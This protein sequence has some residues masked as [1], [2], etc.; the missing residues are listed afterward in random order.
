MKVV[1]AEEMKALDEKAVSECKI[2]SLFLMEN[3]A[4]G[5]A[6]KI[7]EKIS[8]VAGLPII[9]FCG[10]GRNGG[11]GL[12]AARH[13]RMRGAIVTVAFFSPIGQSQAS[14]RLSGDTQTMLTAWM[15]TGGTV[16]FFD[17]TTVETLE[18][19]LSESRIIVDALLG[20]GLSHS[21][22]GDFEKAIFLINKTRR[23]Q[24]I[25]VVAVD[26]PSGISADTGERMGASVEAD[27]TFTMGLPKRGLF[28]REGLQCRGSWDIV[29]IGF[30]KALVAQA[31]IKVEL[32]GPADLKGFPHAR[33][34]GAH[35]GTFGHLLIIAGSKGKKGAAVMAS[36]SALRAGCGLVTTALPKSIDSISK[37]GM[38]VMTLPLSE[39]EEGTLSLTAEK[40][41]IN[42]LAKKDAVAMGPGLSQ[43]PETV[44][45][46]LN[47]ITQIEIPMII[48]ADAINALATDLSVLNHRKGPVILTPHA[49]E[50][51]RLLG[52]SS[53]TVQKDRIGTASSFAQKWGVIV[54]LKGA[55]TLIVA[56]DGSVAMANTG[57]PGMATAG[58]G[59]V[60]TGIIGG[61]LAAGIDPL[62]SAIRGVILHGLAGDIACR[63]FGEISLIA[64]DII[65]KIP[66]AILSLSAGGVPSADG[67]PPQKIRSFS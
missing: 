10:K 51:G 40:E 29:D 22:G 64:S 62:S 12:A 18:K 54:V 17:A 42:A 58:T 53:E 48:D 57:N 34:L 19:K 21:V 7:E 4:R 13:F 14:S 2:P 38:E 1:T 59:D 63:A 65:H 60:L 30:P 15:S 35:K 50:M 32:M 52:V 39:T 20:T 36:L 41:L 67:V 61:F 28:L 46:I 43:H 23:T 3:A 25:T 11:D 8:R 6:D 49:G 9:I 33:L 66:D 45:L 56:P 37:D 31:N 16:Y 27:Y 55:H 26:I 24:G 5:L 47:L 44:R